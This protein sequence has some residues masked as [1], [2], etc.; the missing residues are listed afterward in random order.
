MRPMAGMPFSVRQDPIEK[1]APVALP[2][3]Q[4]LGVC[5]SRTREGLIWRLC[6]PD[7]GEIMDHL[8]KSEY[9]S[10]A[11]YRQRLALLSPSCSY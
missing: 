5:E 6:P 8:L 11:T 4:S 3:G 1:P 7:G 2:A 10:V 9:P